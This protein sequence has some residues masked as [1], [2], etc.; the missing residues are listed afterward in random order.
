MESISAF[1]KGEA[2]AQRQQLRDIAAAA[3]VRITI[4]R[5]DNEAIGVFDCQDQVYR[6]MEN[7]ESVQLSR[8]RC[9]A[10]V[11]PV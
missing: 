4:Y 8:K 1:T 10:E 3:E 9:G 11:E 7:C 5:K 6:R 2:F